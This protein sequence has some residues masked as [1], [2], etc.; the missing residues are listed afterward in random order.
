MYMGGAVKKMPTRKNTS[1]SSDL[2]VG[3][4]SSGDLGTIRSILLG[5]FAT[6]AESRIAELETRIKELEL[7]L[8]AKTKSVRTAISEEQAERRAEIARLDSSS[9]DGRQDFTK[10]VGTVKAELTRSKKST[11]QALETSSKN[12]AKLDQEIARLNAAAMDR[13]AL[14]ECFRQLAETIDPN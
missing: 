8:V 13:V 5:E 3:A 10:S 12:I 2:D 4:I 11:A 7:K 14:S 9:K 1:T 6:Q